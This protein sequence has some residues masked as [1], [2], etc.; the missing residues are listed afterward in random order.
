MGVTYS[1]RE[2]KIKLRL[3]HHDFC[4]SSRKLCHC[5]SLKYFITHSFNYNN[6]IFREANLRVVAW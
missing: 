5:P 6:V 2:R 4:D 3:R 1:F